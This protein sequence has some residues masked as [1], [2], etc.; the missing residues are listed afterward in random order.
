MTGSGTQT[1]PYIVDS[2]SEF[3]SIGINSNSGVYVHFNPDA[4]NKIIDMNDIYPEGCPSYDIGSSEIYGNGWEIRNL[5]LKNPLFYAAAYGVINGF[6]FTSFRHETSSPFLAAEYSYYDNYGCLFE[7]NIFSGITKSNVFFNE[8]LGQKIEL[9]NSSFDLII[10]DDVTFRLANGI[11]S[12]SGN[13]KK[14]IMFNNIKIQLTGNSKINP[15]GLFGECPNHNFANNR[16]NVIANTGCDFPI[17]QSAAGFSGN[18][19]LGSNTGVIS[20]LGSGTCSGVNIYNSDTLN[21]TGTDSR[22]K[23]CTTEQLRSAEYL[24][25]IGFAIGVEE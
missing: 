7:K 9:Y 21:Y 3:E 13:F 19:I 25:S 16:I 23:G 20:P 6:K 4:E 18:V 22:F 2:W 5:Y 10:S 1:D 17:A 11:S 15:N 14:D 8:N 24:Q 12:G